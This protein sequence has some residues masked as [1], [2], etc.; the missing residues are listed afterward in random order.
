MIR[1][2]HVVLRAVVLA[3]ALAGTIGP[4]R[5]LA[6]PTGRWSGHYHCAQGNTALDLTITPAGPGK[7]RALFFFHALVG[8]PHVPPGCFSMA[9]RYDAASGHLALR[10]T[11]WLLRPQHF[12]WVGLRGRIDGAGGAMAGQIDGPGCTDFSLV[13]VDGKVPASVPPACRM[14]RGAPTV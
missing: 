12:V 1:R 13:R 9:G 3:G 7:V 8:N 4:G 14:E 10:P 2:R 6:A 11:M 5:I